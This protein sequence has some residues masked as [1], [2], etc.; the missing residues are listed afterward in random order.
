MVLNDELTAVIVASDIAGEFP[1][2]SPAFFRIWTAK[3][4]EICAG[5]DV[6]SVVGSS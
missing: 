5:G 2:N 3:S 4:F 1:L 6:D